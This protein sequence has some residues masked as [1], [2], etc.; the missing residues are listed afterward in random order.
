MSDWEQLGSLCLWEGLG[1]QGF[2]GGGGG[3]LGVKVRNFGVIGL[4]VYGLGFRLQG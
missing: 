3:G 4:E 1:L 2:F